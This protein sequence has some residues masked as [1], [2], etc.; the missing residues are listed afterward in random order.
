VAKR[1]NAGNERDRSARSERMTGIRVASQATSSDERH[2]PFIYIVSRYIRVRQME[3]FTS[4][5]AQIIEE[6]R[7]FR[8]LER[9][10]A[11]PLIPRLPFSLAQQMLYAAQQYVCGSE[12]PKLADL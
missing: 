10:P 12:I 7:N 2:E 3:D 9:R 5:P 1:E 8:Q 6:W 11:P 4:E